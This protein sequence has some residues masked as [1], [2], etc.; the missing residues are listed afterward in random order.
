[1]FNIK[2]LDLSKM[3][4]VNFLCAVVVS[5]YQGKWI[6]VR[7]KGKETW[8]LPGGT[9]ESG[10]S[11]TETAKR[12]L[13]EETGAI[14]FSL[15]PIAITSVNIEGK[16]SYGLLCYSEISELGRLPESEIEEV[17]MFDNL[18]DKL[19]YPSIHDKLFNRVV[20]YCSSHI[21]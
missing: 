17:K 7:E 13:F 8:E 10:E 6:F 9:H 15:V 12:E 18:P 5:R 20:E 14:R 19:T 4:D 3:E 21:L 11:I 2:I 16:E 1:M